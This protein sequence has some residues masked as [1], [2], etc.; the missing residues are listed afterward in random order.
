MKNLDKECWIVFYRGNGY[1]I[2]LNE[3]FANEMAK[4]LPERNEKKFKTNQLGKYSVNIYKA[5]LKWA[6]D[7]LK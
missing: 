4:I 1:G 7:N 5:N 3:K 2:F 6:I